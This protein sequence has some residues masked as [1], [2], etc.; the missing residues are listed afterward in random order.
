[1]WILLLVDDVHSE[2]DLREDSTSS[3]TR[4]SLNG[5]KLINLAP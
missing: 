2:A 4:S 3:G 1:M 5:I